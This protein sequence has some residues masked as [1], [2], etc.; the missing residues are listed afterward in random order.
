MAIALCA[1]GKRESNN[2]YK[3]S[4]RSFL[5]NI[6]ELESYLELENELINEVKRESYSNP[7]EYA[8]AISN[9]LDYK[10]DMKYKSG[11]S[12]L[13]T[14]LKEGEGNCLAS[15]TLKY[16]A[17]SRLV[18]GIDINVVT[19]K[20]HIALSL[21]YQGKEYFV[22]NTVKG[23]F[24][25]K[26]NVSFVR[27]KGEDA[28]NAIIAALLNNEAISFLKIG[29][30]DLAIELYQ[31]ALKYNNRMKDIYINLACLLNGK[32]KE[33]YLSIAR[34]IAMEKL[35]NYSLEDVVA[36]FDVPKKN[37]KLTKQEELDV[38]STIYPELDLLEPILI[39]KEVMLNIDNVPA[40]DPK[41]FGIY[42]KYYE[43]YSPYDDVKSYS[44]KKYYSLDE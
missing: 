13:S 18:D 22:E 21:E 36:A 26:T 30:R 15:T 9:Y 8:K 7:I 40:L 20:G 5:Y 42:Y 44:M 43:F 41:K 14:L 10:V 35:N 29:K 17:L 37:E 27:H 32:E 31:R 19:P 34:S 1:Y 12:S 28:Q 33:K 2:N 39:G 3:Q 23:G 11:Q 6:G 4:L 25:Y 24:D 16:L 38:K